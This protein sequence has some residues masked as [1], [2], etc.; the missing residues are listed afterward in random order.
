M[1]SRCVPAWFS[2]KIN[3]Q[4]GGLDESGG[5]QVC[6]SM[7]LSLKVCSSTKMHGERLHTAVFTRLL[8]M[9]LNTQCL[10]FAIIR[11]R[12]LP[13]SAVCVTSA[14][15]K[16]G[17]YTWQKYRKRHEPTVSALLWQRANQHG[18]ALTE[19]LKFAHPPLHPPPQKKK[20]AKTTT[21]KS[22]AFM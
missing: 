15:T 6:S 7:V 12:V 16:Q 11:P 18:C 9:L 17:W 3:G 22:T 5:L 10:K 13:L 8:V 14:V 1:I 21:T 20:Q 4:S 19:E 2:L